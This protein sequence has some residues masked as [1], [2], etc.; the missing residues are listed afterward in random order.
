MS[1]DATIDPSK[2]G[3][4]PAAGQVINIDEIPHVVVPDNCELQNMEE[5]MDAPRRI[6]A[7]VAFY[8]LD[9]FLK[10]LADFAATDTQIF[11]K[12][13]PAGMMA[14]AII[15]YPEKD[16]PRWGS[17]RAGLTTVHSTEW[18]RWLGRNKQHMTQQQFIE[19]VED[20]SAS[21]VQ[22]A[23]NEML[24]IARDLEMTI[25][26]EWKG[27]VRENGDTSLSYVNTS[28]AG[29]GSL[30]VPQSFVVLLPIFQGGASYQLTARLRPS[31][32]EGK[33]M[34]R[35]ELLQPEKLVEAATKDILTRIT[36]EAKIT[37]L[38]GDA[39]S[40]V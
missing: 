26:V 20:N 3:N 39:P 37:P 38:I 27:A 7:N 29:A 12:V 15:D 35:Y 25:N 32:Q 9:S 34:M 1:L 14:I 8:E 40:K 17:H 23:G 21:F 4:Y 10:Y 24:T 28:K 33:L 11:A 16:T 30:A 2:L 36:K 19:F 22:P 31:L 6:R 5:A 13:N 18:T